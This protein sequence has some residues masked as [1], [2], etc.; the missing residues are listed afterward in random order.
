MKYPVS[1]IC[2]F[3]ILHICFKTTPIIDNPITQNMLVCI[4]SAV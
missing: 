4:F 2:C 1:W 3:S